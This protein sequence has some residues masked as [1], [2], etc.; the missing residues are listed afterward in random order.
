M[1]ADRPEPLIFTAWLR[2]VTRRIVEDELG[3]AW[4]RYWRPNPLFTRA[5]LENRGGLG[6]WCDDVE[7]L[8]VIEPCS[9][10]LSEGLGAAL[11]ELSSAYAGS[12]SAWRWGHAH[13]A[14][15]VHL[16]FGFVGPLGR[17]FN[18]ETETGGGDF[19]VNRGRISY[20][21]TPPYRNRHGSGYRA[22]YDLSTEDGGRFMISTGQS[23]N[24]FSR[25]YDNLAERWAAGDFLEITADRARIATR[26][27]GV[28][29]LKPS[30]PPEPPVRD[31]EI[32]WGIRRP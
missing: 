12:P 24:P 17:L 14:V 23:G 18:I 26:M 15:H 16:P 27:A 19:T 31:S 32:P 29:R 2:A 3:D 13:E 9:A 20:G 28:I 7:T 6:R 30:A 22:I 11:D 25:Y 10:L 8:I 4:E 1:A 21:S 5:V